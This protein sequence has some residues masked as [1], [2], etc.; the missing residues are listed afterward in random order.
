MNTSSRI[1]WWILSVL[2]YCE[3]TRGYS[4][5]ASGEYTSEYFASIDDSSPPLRQTSLSGNGWSARFVF[6]VCC[7]AFVGKGWHH[8]GGNQ[9]SPRVIFGA[10]GEPLACSFPFFSIHYT[11]M[12]SMVSLRVFTKSVNKLPVCTLSPC[13]GL[14]PCYNKKLMNYGPR[15]RTTHQHKEAKGGHWTRLFVGF[16]KFISFVRFAAFYSK[17]TAL[18]FSLF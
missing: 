13:F 17:K 4:C 9:W 16:P 14:L 12:L 10:T 8:F 6:V 18:V 5:E 15:R 3:N 7:S 11:F 2:F 1:V